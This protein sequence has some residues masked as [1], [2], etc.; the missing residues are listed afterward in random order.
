M[1]LLKTKIKIL[2]LI[3]FSILLMFSGSAYAGTTSLDPTDIG[4]G[5]SSIS[6]G[7]TNI[8][9]L[10]DINGFFVNPA[11]GA[12]IKNWGLTS[13]YTS[14]LENDI[15]YAFFG[16]VTKGLG[17]VIG[18]SYI[19]GNSSGILVTTRDA[20]SR[21]IATGNSIDYSNSTFMLSYSREIKEDLSAGLSL[22][23]FD[24]SFTGQ[25]S[26]HGFDAD[27]GL[28]YKIIDEFV[29]GVVLKDF[30]PEKIGGLTWTTG[31]SEDTPTN[32]KGGL[33]CKLTDNFTIKTDVSLSPFNLNLGAQWQV[34]PILFLRG[35][36]EQ[37]S[38]GSSSKVLNSMLGLG[39]NAGSFSFD[40][41]YFKDGA[42]DSNST[43]F[44]SI[45][46]AP[47]HKTNKMIKENDTVTIN[48]EIPKP[49][50]E[51]NPGVVLA[52]SAVK[53]SSSKLK[54]D[55]V[56]KS[57]SG[58]KAANFKKNKAKS[59]SI[60]KVKYAKNKEKHIKS[61]TKSFKI[62]NRKIYKYRKTK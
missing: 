62:K 46:Y 6:M 19:G 52:S 59:N 38:V 28:A 14:L 35:G 41:S 2:L 10:G 47:A 27:V 29:L 31:T 42:I 18:F 57:L 33:S 17:G 25:A 5:A 50:N 53:E 9:N 24:K 7:R 43:H 23:Y 32:L 8:V 1:I 12:Y 51:L 30:L 40:Y 48:K 4:L 55:K 3:V 36:I 13:M 34:L 61:K 39:I 54:S 56:V 11:N 60:K 16:T 21:I 45:S 26:G 20:D 22:K 44:F 37:L 15:S 49:K 58:K